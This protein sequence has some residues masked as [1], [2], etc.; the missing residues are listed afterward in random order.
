MNKRGLSG[1]IIA[2]L[3][4]ALALIITGVLVILVGKLVRDNAG[5]ISFADIRTE[6]DV[7]KFECGIDKGVWEITLENTGRKRE[8]F[9]ITGFRFTFESES[10]S[11]G[12]IK[13]NKSLRAGAKETYTINKSDIEQTDR[14]NL[15]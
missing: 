4:I 10:E 3:L 13:I 12:N 9:E 8:N 14:Q 6:I 15:I 7:K 5:N 1:I 2:F 11:W